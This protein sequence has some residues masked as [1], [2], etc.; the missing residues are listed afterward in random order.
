MEDIVPLEAEDDCCMTSAVKPDV[1][2]IG[3]K[4][5]DSNRKMTGS[6]K[7]KPQL[8]MLHSTKKER[9]KIASIFMQPSVKGGLIA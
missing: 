3:D 8:R 6:T 1:Y 9:T 4:R 2:V 5:N 7:P